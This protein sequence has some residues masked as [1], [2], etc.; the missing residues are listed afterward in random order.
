MFK[1]IELCRRQRRKGYQRRALRGVA[2]RERWRYDGLLLF[3][4]DT[5]FRRDARVQRILLL[6][7][8]FSAKPL[9]PLCGQPA[10]LGSTV[11]KAVK[12]VT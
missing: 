1:F 8:F 5:G 11:H 7:N 12:F 10:G 9:D 3:A 4:M 6:G 2:L